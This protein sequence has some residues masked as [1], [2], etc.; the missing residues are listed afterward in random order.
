[1]YKSW[2]TSPRA[3]IADYTR[4]VL[5]TI[6][7]TN[8]VDI[9]GDGLIDIMYNSYLTNAG[10]YLGIL[11]NTGDYSFKPVYKCR[12]VTTGAPNYIPTYYGDCADTNFR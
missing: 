10:G 3:K 8:F 2:A 7:G 4:S 9:N 12:V 1:M 6:T 5:G 11:V